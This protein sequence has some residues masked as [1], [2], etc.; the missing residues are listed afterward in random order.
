[1]EI[2]FWFFDFVGFNFLNSISGLFSVCQADSRVWLL[3]NRYN[4]GI[5]PTT[6]CRVP[7]L[8]RAGINTASGHLASTILTRH[9]KRPLNSCPDWHGRC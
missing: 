6:R 4:G 3:E 8:G 1:V 9:V 7:E 5:P 2:G